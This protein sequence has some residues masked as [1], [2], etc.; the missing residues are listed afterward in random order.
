[1]IANGT[2]AATRLDHGCGGKSGQQAMKHKPMHMCSTFLAAWTLRIPWCC[3]LVVRRPQQGATSRSQYTA[4]FTAS[5]ASAVQTQAAQRGSKESTDSEA[6]V[7]SAPV[8]AMIRATC[9][10]GKPC[11]AQLRHCS[12]EC[13]LERDKQS[14]TATQAGVLSMNGVVASVWNTRS[15]YC[16]VRDS[17]GYWWRSRCGAECVKHQRTPP[18]PPYAGSKAV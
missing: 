16:H 11:V 8:S 2:D 7:A 5:E 18:E 12:F 4:A 10:A 14:S 13:K 15:N 17:G 9:G 6:P 3:R 1:M